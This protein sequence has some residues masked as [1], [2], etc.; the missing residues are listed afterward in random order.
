MTDKINGVEVPID[1][2][3]GASIVD[4]IQIVPVVPAPVEKEE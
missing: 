4:H 2:T 1:A 3:K